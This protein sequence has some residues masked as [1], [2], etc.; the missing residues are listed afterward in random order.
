[1]YSS[2]L[3]IV[4][5]SLISN[6]Y[7]CWHFR[8]TA[9]RHYQLRHVSVRLSVGRE[10]LG[11]QWTNF[12]EI[13]Y[14]SIFRKYF[15]EILASLKSDKNKAYLTWRRMYVCDILLNSSSNEKCRR[16][17]VEK[18]KTH[19]TC[20]T[21]FFSRKWCLLWYNIRK[22]WYSHTGHRWQHNTTY[23]HCMPDT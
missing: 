13:L 10:K 3:I 4:A 7:I 12:H 22:I 17:V 5:V 18:T 20:S 11:S 1:L 16:K 14:L 19:V 2:L 9:N 6:K 8:K 23:E 15:G 21:T